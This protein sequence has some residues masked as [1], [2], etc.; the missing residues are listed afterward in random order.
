M[1]DKA[2][3]ENGGTLESVRD[4]YK[5]QEMCNK[6]VDSYPHAL[7]FVPE[8][9]ITQEMRD[10]VVS[11]HSSAIRFVSERYKTQKMW[12]EVLNKSVLAFFTYLIDIKLK[13]C[14]AVLFVKIFFNK[15]C[16]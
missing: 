3:L 5:N 15:I 8:W 12:D 10:K 13:K 4:C 11:T 16:S 7:E 9:Y 2:I 6:A 1:C 14:V